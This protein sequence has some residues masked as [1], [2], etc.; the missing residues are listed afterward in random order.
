[1]QK[2]LDEPIIILNKNTGEEL[3]VYRGGK[4]RRELS[5]AAVIGAALICILLVILVV[6]IVSRILKKLM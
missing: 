1:M 2:A 3:Y 4:E 6:P 5:I